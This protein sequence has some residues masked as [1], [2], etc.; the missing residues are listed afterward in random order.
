MI[1]SKDTRL[2]TTHGVI[3]A[4]CLYAAMR[5]RYRL[6]RAGVAIACLWQAIGEEPLHTSYPVLA[7][8]GIWLG[9]FLASICDWVCGDHESSMGAL[10][11]S[12]VA[13]TILFDML[14]DADA[15]TNLSR[16][17]DSLYVRWEKP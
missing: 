11:L 3:V 4:L 8:F 10:V 12:W 2:L 7:M 6:R 9:L 1:D 17:I 5:V 16:R 13:F 14:K 15:L